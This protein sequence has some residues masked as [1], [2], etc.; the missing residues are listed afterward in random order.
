MRLLG[1]ASNDEYKKLLQQIFPTLSTDGLVPLLSDT[2]R[3][4][5][6]T[7]GMAKQLT[8]MRKTFLDGY[9]KSLDHVLQQIWEG[10]TFARRKDYLQLFDSLQQSIELMTI[11]EKDIARHNQAYNARLSII[12]GRCSVQT[13][14]SYRS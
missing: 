6:G 11:L 8:D 3:S 10:E 9:S 12:S 7:Y 14:D 13:S 4:E 1:K 5:M 2:K